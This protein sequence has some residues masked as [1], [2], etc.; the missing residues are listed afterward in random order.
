MQKDFSVAIVSNATTVGNILPNHN[1]RKGEFLLLA[2]VA[3]GKNS[4]QTVD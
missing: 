4:P 2:S 1:H 3:V